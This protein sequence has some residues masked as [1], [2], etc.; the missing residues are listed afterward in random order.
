MWEGR[1]ARERGGRQVQPRRACRA[2]ARARRSHRAARSSAALRRALA[3]VACSSASLAPQGGCSGPPPRAAAPAPQAMAGAPADG[4]AGGTSPSPSPGAPVAV[5]S[6]GENARALRQARP[7]SPKPQT[8]NQRLRAGPQFSTASEQLIPSRSSSSSN[9]QRGFS[10]QTGQVCS[11]LQQAS[12]GEAAC[13]PATHDCA[14]GGA[15]EPRQ[16]A[17]ALFRDRLP[18]GSRPAMRRGSRGNRNDGTWVQLSG[19]CVAGA[20]GADCGRRRALPRRGRRRALR[21][22]VSNLGLSALNSMFI[23]ACEVFCNIL[24]TG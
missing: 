17:W 16:P 21:S 22:W 6:L 8:A 13:A 1:G 15:P 5:R 18:S 20:S 11:D 24:A 14:P 7:A 10:Y 23:V 19:C 9:L 3:A 12:R 2:A 4:T